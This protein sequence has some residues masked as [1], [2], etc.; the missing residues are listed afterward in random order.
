MKVLTGMELSWKIL[1]WGLITNLKWLK[2]VKQKVEEMRQFFT[3]KEN[4]WGAVLANIFVNDLDKGWIARWR[5]LLMLQNCQGVTMTTGY[6]ELQMDFMLWSDFE[7][8]ME[9]E[10][11]HW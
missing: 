6:E 11:Q 2:D 7:D 10:I 5:R 3:M 9:D 4:Y 8:K 1:L